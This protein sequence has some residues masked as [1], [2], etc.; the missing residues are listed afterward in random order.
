[1]T[2]GD[3]KVLSARQYAYYSDGENSAG[4]FIRRLNSRMKAM[5]DNILGVGILLMFNPVAW[6]VFLGQTVPDRVIEKKSALSCLTDW[7][8][9]EDKMMEMINTGEF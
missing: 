4:M 3:L 8:K 6:L 7:K 1:M 5:A 9:T 2:V